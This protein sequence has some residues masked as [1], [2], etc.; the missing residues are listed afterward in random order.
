MEAFSLRK[1]LSD[2]DATLQAFTT[3]SAHLS[4]STYVTGICLDIGLP[5]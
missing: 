3:P 2:S 4:H 1:L 5:H